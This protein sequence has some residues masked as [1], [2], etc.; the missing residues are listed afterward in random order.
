MAR[1]DCKNILELVE[2]FEDDMAY[3]VVSKFMPAGDLYTYICRQPSQPLDEEHT[4]LIIKQVCQG[5]QAL[6]KKNIIHRDIK[7]ENIL[8]SMTA[9]GAQGLISPVDA[10][11]L[12][13]P[14][15]D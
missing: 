15:K 9:A 2:V 8:S 5:V 14:K 10:Q 12:K 4:K 1:S 3:Y 7:I 13:V 11:L 6:H